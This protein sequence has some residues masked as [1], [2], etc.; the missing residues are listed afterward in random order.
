MKKFS[1]LSYRISGI[2]DNGLDIITQTLGQ[3][4]SLKA[5]DLDFS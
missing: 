5:L 2:T 4:T 1:N 3:L